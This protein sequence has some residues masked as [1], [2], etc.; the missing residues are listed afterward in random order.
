[1]EVSKFFSS[2]G[3]QRLVAGEFR[4]SCKAERS[5]NQKPSLPLAHQASLL[6]S[7]LFASIQAACLDCLM[8]QYYYYFHGGNTTN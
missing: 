4:R 5:K 1:M 7:S 6:A 2:S 8:L 3:V